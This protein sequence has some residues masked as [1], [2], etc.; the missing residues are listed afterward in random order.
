[1]LMEHQTKALTTKKRVNLV[2]LLKKRRKKQTNQSCHC[3]QYNR[4]AKQ[5]HQPFIVRIFFRFFQQ[6]REKRR[7]DRYGKRRRKRLS[8][9]G[10]SGLFGFGSLGSSQGCFRRCCCCLCIASYH[11]CCF[12]RLS[13]RSPYNFSSSNNK[14]STK[15]LQRAFAEQLKLWQLATMNAIFCDSEKK[16]ID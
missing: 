13:Y 3:K 2:K 8:E 7:I 11:F 12:V 16:R 1:M 9:N 14:T 10:F 15:Y 4:K 6:N 5:C